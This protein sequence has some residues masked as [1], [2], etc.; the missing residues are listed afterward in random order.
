MGSQNR[1]PEV[2]DILTPRSSSISPTSSTPS[3]SPEHRRMKRSELFNCSESLVNTPI[4][5]MDNLSL[6]TMKAHSPEG[7][8]MKFQPLNSETCSTEN[9]GT[10]PE[11][12]ATKA[13]SLEMLDARTDR[14]KTPDMKAHSLESHTLPT[15]EKKKSKSV[16]EADQKSKADDD[17]IEIIRIE[18]EI[19]VVKS[20]MAQLSD[21]SGNPN[22]DRQTEPIDSMEVETS[23]SENSEERDPTPN[24]HDMLGDTSM[25]STVDERNQGA[26][27]CVAQRTRSHTEEMRE[28]IEQ[29][30]LLNLSKLKEIYTEIKDEKDKSRLEISWDCKKN[31][32]NDSLGLP[33]YQINT[34]L[35]EYK[36]IHN[37]MEVLEKSFKE[38]T[39]IEKKHKKGV[40]WKDL[41]T[42]TQEE[43]RDE[44]MKQG[45]I[46]YVMEDD[47]Y[48]SALK[49]VN[50]ALE[51]LLNMR[52]NTVNMNY[53]ETVVRFVVSLCLDYNINT[54]YTREHACNGQIHKR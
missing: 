41:E 22:E 50:H 31:E 18:K 52:I 32:A 21:N 3:S 4:A 33:A 47:D 46:T 27:S 9:I 10:R 8:V 6:Q 54:G 12:P 36:Q 24:E 34:E 44:Q 7:E 25:D 40:T 35:D 51:T 39:V 37:T 53:M 19:K 17:E 1:S 14:T 28:K 16:K 49:V 13:S 42:G 38:M 15:K 20:M 23:L 43:E 48:R 26:R 5:Q 30:R 45:D 11:S 29:T 2:E